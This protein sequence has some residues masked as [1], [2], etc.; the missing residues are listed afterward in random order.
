MGL[1]QFAKDVGRKLRL[2]DDEP[3]QPAGGAGHPSTQQV[4]DLHDRRRAAALVKVVEQMGFKVQ[5]FSV[6]VDGDKAVVKGKAASQEEREKVALLVGNHEGIGSVDDQMT[7]GGGAVGASYQGQGQ[8][9]TVVKG[10][11]L[12][13]I[14]KQHYGDANAYN[15]IFEANRPLLKDADEIYP[16]QV[17][18]IPAQTEAPTRA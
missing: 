17:L 7:V 16:G 2:G 3:Q 8:F 18:R 13:K 4:Q 14:A 11:T 10:D 9:Y 6:R 5:D 12:S 1:I 15:R